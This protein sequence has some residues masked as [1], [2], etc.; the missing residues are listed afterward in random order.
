MIIISYCL[1]Y[2]VLLYFTLL[3]FVKISLT[4]DIDEMFARQKILQSILDH[5]QLKKPLPIDVSSSVR[6]K[7]ENHIDKINEHDENKK[8]VTFFDIPSN[9]IMFP[10]IFFKIPKILRSYI[11]KE[12][13][14]KLDYYS[15]T[16]HDEEFFG[17]IYVTT[18]DNE[19]M[20]CIGNVTFEKNLPLNGTI[21]I[22][23]NINL[24]S[25]IIDLNEENIE[26]FIKIH[27]QNV[28]FPYL[29]NFASLKFHSIDTKER[30]KRNVENICQS[31]SSENSCC[32]RL[33]KIN[34][35]EIGWNFILSP[36]EI[37]TNYCYG[38]CY[39]YKSDSLVGDAIYRLYSISKKEHKRCCYPTQFR[40]LNITIFKEGSFIETKI[41]NDILIKKCSCY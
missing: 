21:N 28:T 37:N 29:L 24:L 9:K 27:K 40:E 38:K 26:I 3:S 19:I 8:F 13:S 39:S 12:G 11:F 5:F 17:N 16:D 2:I 25:K 18:K 15:Y 14:I 4:N 20:E 23:L 32:L 41:I 31:K 36:K 10:I 33:L 6:K 7:Y 22:P 34:F 30:S 35:D 1:L